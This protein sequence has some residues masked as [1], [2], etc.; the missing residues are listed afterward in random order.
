MEVCTEEFLRDICVAM[1]VNVWS[2]LSNCGDILLGNHY[3]PHMWGKGSFRRYGNKVI[4]R[5][6]PQ[7]SIL[8]CVLND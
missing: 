1:H 7:R 2:V 5:D 3:Q 8:G 4:D 6:D